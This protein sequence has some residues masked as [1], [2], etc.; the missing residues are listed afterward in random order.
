MSSQ[1]TSM[2]ATP[3]QTPRAGSPYRVYVMDISY[4][5]GK[6]EAYLRYKR[7][8]YTRIEAHHAVLLDPVYRMTGVAQVPAVELPDGG[9]LRDSTA[10]LRWFEQAHPQRPVRPA[11]PAL[12][13]LMDLV[14]DYADEWLWRPAMWWRWMPYGSARNLGWRIATEIGHSTFGPAWIK[15]PGFA[16]RQR[17]TWLWGDGMTRDNSRVIRDMYFAQLEALEGILAEH[18]FLLGVRPSLADFGYFASMF[19]HFFCDPDSGVVMR[20]RAPRVVEWVARLWNAA[21]LPDDASEFVAP[22]GAGWESILGDLAERY[23]PYLEQNGAAY[24]AGKRRFDASLPGLDL[25]NSVTHRHRAACLAALQ[26]GFQALGE[27]ERAS[28]LRHFS[29][30]PAVAAILG[31]APD[32]HVPELAASPIRAPLGVRA[33]FAQRLKARVFGTPR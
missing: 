9:W 3:L 17:R 20:Q 27:T 4:F 30:P 23:L 16:W 32:A 22:A 33:S 29:N 15:A 8:P 6:V 11:D 5:S 24:A 13:F 2:A 14:E 26:V 10:I 18:P 1:F 28:V 21:S 12:A 19:R 25:P 31:R 7:I